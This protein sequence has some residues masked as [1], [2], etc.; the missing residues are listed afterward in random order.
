M[1]NRFTDTFQLSKKKKI[2]ILVAIFLGIFVGLYEYTSTEDV[3][4]SPEKKLKDIPTQLKKQEEQ[5]INASMA[6]SVYPIDNNNDDNELWRAT[7]QEQINNVNSNVE[8]LSKD[9]ATQLD[10]IS[11]QAKQLN[12]QNAQIESMNEKLDILAKQAASQVQVSKSEKVHVQEQVNLIKIGSMDGGGTAIT[13][14]DKLDSSSPIVNNVDSSSSSSN[15]Q[16]NKSNTDKHHNTAEY[17]PSQSFVTANLISALDA[18]TGGNGN[19]NPTP[20][21]M[22]LTDYAQLPNFFRANIKNCFVGG[23]GFGNLSTERVDIRLTNM[24]CTLRNGHVLDIPVSGFVV[25]EDSKAG[26]KGVVVTNN[27]SKLAMALLAGTAGGLA[28]AAQTSTQTQM[29]SPIGV[30]NTINPSQAT[31]SAL[32]GGAG[33]GFNLLSNYYTNLLNQITPTIMVSSGRHVS[34][35]FTQG[36]S[37]DYPLDGQ[38]ITNDST[39]LPIE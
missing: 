14:N 38:G 8:H 9:N 32:A 7:G 26:L 17:I 10:K 11:E 18:N 22:R 39:P 12:S 35:V 16:N 30:T 28:N 4:D 34:I 24:S 37:L 3:I 13:S 33:Q 19:S 23:S 6:Q 20:V 27:G 2:G 31:S 1:S 36:I 5:K 15:S 21:L 29:V 25:G